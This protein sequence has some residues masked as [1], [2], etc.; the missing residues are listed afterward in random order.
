MTTSKAIVF[1]AP[2]EVSVNPIEIPAPASGQLLIKTHY[3][4]VSTGTEAR[5][6][7]G[8][9]TGASFPLIPG[10][11]NVGEIVDCGEDTSLNPGNLCFHMGSDFTAKYAGVWGAHQ[12][13]SLVRESDVF[14]VPP[15]LDPLDAVYA[16]VGAIALHGIRRAK[17]S[18]EDTV[19]VVG[20]GLIG[21][22]A[23][24]CAK[25]R[26]ARVI[27]V[28]TNPQRLNRAAA[29]GIPFLIDASKQDIGKKV[30]EYGN[31]NVSVAIDVTG[32]ADNIKN[33]A[34]L[35]RT[36]P[37]EP[38]YPPSPRLVVLGSYSDPLKL[39]YDPLFMNEVDILFSRDVIAA[40]VEQMLNLLAAK[41]ITPAALKA[42][43]YK[44]DE[45]PK[46]YKELIEKQLMR[47][48]FEW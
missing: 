40:D 1:S 38:P 21:H 41:K 7:K 17:V 46:A 29:G 31:N 35:V 32:V 6:L 25:A 12:Q 5:V 16:K 34:E 22:L 20:L 10:Y 45:A 44:A 30:E 23:A 36:M 8:G 42:K 3:S 15:A 2:F 48:V 47:I 43:C 28:D 14:V 26:H 24:Q 33:T 9:Q 27:G 4:G 37:W 11:E 19:V 39:D 18:Q 13:Y